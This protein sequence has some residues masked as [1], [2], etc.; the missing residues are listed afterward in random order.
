MNPPHSACVSVGD[1]LGVCVSLLLLVG[2]LGLRLTAVVNGIGP[3]FVFV[4][5][6]A[7]SRQR[8]T[9]GSQSLMEYFLELLNVS[10]PTVA[11]CPLLHRRLTR[12]EAS[13]MHCQLEEALTHFHC[14]SEYSC[15][16]CKVIR[17]PQV[18]QRV[19]HDLLFTGD[20]V[21]YM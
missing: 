12:M 16:H 20:R 5:V 7:S 21:V 17:N 19:S 10:A 3:V 6:F 18:V 11:C 1:V 8:P 4:L 9:S 14:R 15:P 2:H 13:A